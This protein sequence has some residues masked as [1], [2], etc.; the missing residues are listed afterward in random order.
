MSEIQKL[1]DEAKRLFENSQFEKSADLLLHVAQLYVKSGHSKYAID[2]YNNAAFCFYKGGNIKRAIQAY[3]DALELTEKL[4]NLEGKVSQLT[5]IGR[6]FK[7]SGN[8]NKA[9]SYYQEALGIA[10]EIQYSKGIADTLTEIGTILYERKKY[11]DALEKYLLALEFTTQLKDKELENTLAF[12]ISKI[13][14]NENSQSLAKSICKIAT[15]YNKKD[16]NDYALFLSKNA[17][18]LFK[19][20]NY[21][22]ETL[23]IM[24]NLGNIYES[25]GLNNDAIQI[26][27]EALKI[28]EQKGD[29]KMSIRLTN[30]IKKLKSNS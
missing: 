9:F 7:Q 12:N 21:I 10:E 16:K 27:T 11:E 24:N 5:G 14:N 2:R 13:L 26:Y 20:M 22:D 4:G 29:S 8:A 15:D 18:T 30:V 3:K 23:M 17:I 19:D 25:Q 6:M 1:L 28:C